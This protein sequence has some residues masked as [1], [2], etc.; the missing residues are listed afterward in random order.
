MMKISGMNGMGPQAG[1]GIQ[2]TDMESRNIKEQIARAQ[3]QLQE[4]S[5][6]EE[7]SAEEKMKK[8]QEIQ[9][10][11]TEL[12]NQ[13]RQHQIELRREKQ[14]AK[15]S[16]IDELTG[17]SRAA[18]KSG[19]KG[20]G[21]SK[22]GMKALISADSAI[23]LAKSQEN[24]ATSLEGRARV[25]KAE[26]QQ[27]AGRSDVEAKEE[28]LAEV[29]ELAQKA[30]AS[31][32]DTLGKA[33]REMKEAK[34]QEREAGPTETGHSEKD[35]TETERIEDHAAEQATGAEAAENG[36]TGHR[37]TESQTVWNYTS[38]DVRL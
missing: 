9:K 37:D 16:S 28:E 12:N 14:Q 1:Q 33:N 17:G 31:Q 3:K 19:R 10:Q 15:S 35:S 30:T 21:L 38:V 6:K 36:T 11:I 18:E 34:E 23:D 32:I 13:L 20:T 7:L 8:R 22:A 2:G 25:L 24:T 29:E 26:I 27:D 4:L 5:D